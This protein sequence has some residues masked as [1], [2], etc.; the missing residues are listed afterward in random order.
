M[1]VTSLLL[2]VTAAVAVVSGV[3]LLMT[4]CAGSP[5]DHALGGAE[6]VSGANPTHETGALSSPGAAAAEPQRAAAL[7]ISDSE[8]STRLRDL[9]ADLGL[10]DLG[11]LGDQA[12]AA[13][14]DEISDTLARASRRLEELQA[15]PD[16]DLNTQWAVHQK[17]F[18]RLKYSC[19]L[20]CLRAGFYWTFEPGTALELNREMN[21]ALGG[22]CW[23]IHLSTRSNGERP[24]SVVVYVPHDLFPEIAVQRR[25]QQAFVMEHKLQGR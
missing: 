12:L 10:R 1:R 21:E 11:P 13:T 9:P 24:V 22:E 4:S 17:K 14:L 20:A 5:P 15:R 23:F 7:R 2:P 3:V 8:L 25:E 18:T 6:E 19:E 16:P